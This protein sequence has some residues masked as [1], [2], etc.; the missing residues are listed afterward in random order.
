MYERQLSWNVEQYA[1]ERP[2]VLPAFFV[3]VTR[4]TALK[5]YRKKRASKRN[6][7][8]EELTDLTSGEVLFDDDVDRAGEIINRFLE[9]QDKRGRV[10]FMR[11]YYFGESVS[12]AAKVVGMGENNAYVKLSRMRANLK[13]ELEKD[14]INV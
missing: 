8:M 5:L 13:K 14:G 6:A 1:A 11:R 10:L 12:E 3:A 2:A 7:V 9:R 4:N